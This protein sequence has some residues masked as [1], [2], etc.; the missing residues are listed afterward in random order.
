ML[1]SLSVVAL[2]LMVAGI[3]GLYYSHAL[4]SYAPLVIAVQAIA[5]ALMIWARITFG[6]RSFHATANPTEG[7]LVT[8]GPY[9][10]VRHP[11]YTAICLFTIAGASAHI[12]IMSATF[13]LLTLSGSIIRILAEEHLLIK[14][15]PEYQDYAKRVKRMLPL[16]F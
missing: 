6:L 7:R 2:L 8:N 14:Q 16:I 13:V 10:L 9:R 12:S 1:K 15:Y 4:F 11:I 3:F 5:V